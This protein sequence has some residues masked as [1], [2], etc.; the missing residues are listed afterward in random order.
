VGMRVRC[1]GSIARRL[2]LALVPGAIAGACGTA[3]DLD[4]APTGSGGAAAG[5]RATGGTRPRAGASAIGGTGGPFATGGACSGSTCSIGNCCSVANSSCQNGPVECWCQNGIWNPCIAGVTTGGAPS[6]GG[7]A[8]GGACSGSCAPGNCCSTPNSYCVEGNTTCQCVNG[9]WGLCALTTGTGGAPST[10]GAHTGG[11][12][13]G[14][15]ATG[16]NATGGTATGGSAPTGGTGGYGG[17][18]NRLALIT[19][20]CMVQCAAQSG[21][22]CSWENMGLNCVAEICEDPVSPIP[23][24]A[25]A[26]GCEDLYVTMT[27]CAGGLTQNQWECSDQGFDMLWP[28]PV[29]GTA[30]EA[31]TCAWNCCEYNG[32]GFLYDVNFTGARC[33]NCQ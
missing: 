5:V 22:L 24:Y 15:V 16:G 4:L 20:P 30:C 6:T 8:T 2:A 3:S 9:L 27:V 11:K 17:A 1:R 26:V 28:A 10:G 7:R 18:A 14:G 21:L 25:T 23:M 33:G 29:A 31:A 32:G 13:T 12:A 19:E